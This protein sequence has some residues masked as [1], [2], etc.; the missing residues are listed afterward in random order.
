MINISLLQFIRRLSINM[1]RNRR[2]RKNLP[3]NKHYD[4]ITKCV[5]KVAHHSLISN[6]STKIDRQLSSH[7]GKR[8]PYEFVSELVAE[9]Q[10]HFLWLT[11]DMVM[12]HQ[13]K[14]ES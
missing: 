6:V 12:N 14:D 13:R 2:K 7:P 1:L 5:T 11:R 10:E 3:T 8:L 4:K 9:M